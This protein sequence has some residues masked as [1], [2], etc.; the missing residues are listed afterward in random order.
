MACKKMEHNRDFE[1]QGQGSSSGL[2]VGS[3]G[4]QKLVGRVGSG[5]EVFEISR[6]GSDGVRRLSNFTGWV[7][8]GHP[9]SIIPTRRDPTGEIPWNVRRV[10]CVFVVGSDCHVAPHC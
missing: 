10:F 6:I 1:G 4:V 8:S 2:R 9:D 3:G 7:G 5:Q